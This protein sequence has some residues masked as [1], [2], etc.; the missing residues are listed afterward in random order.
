[1]RTGDCWRSRARAPRRLG[2]QPGRP[3][4]GPRP[5]QA[6]VVSWSPL[7][8]LGEE[9]LR[10]LGVDL[11]DDDLCF[12]VVVDKR[13]EA[14]VR[15]VQVDRTTERDREP[16]GDGLYGAE[17]ALT[18]VCVGPPGST[19]ARFPSAAKAI[20]VGGEQGPG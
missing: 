13:D 11:F 9:A 8:S 16:G 15:P 3:P 6:V 12:V 20:C 5:R 19:G 17:H 4:T 14:G 2:T 7:A 18:G 1:M 10:V